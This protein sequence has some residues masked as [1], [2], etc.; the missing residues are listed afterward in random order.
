LTNSPSSNGLIDF[1][2]IAVTCAGVTMEGF[3]FWVPLRPECSY[4]AFPCSL[5]I[6]STYWVFTMRLQPAMILWGIVSLSVT[7]LVRAQDPLDEMY[8]QAVHSFFRGDAQRAEE[9]LTEV[10][11]AGSF[12]P[13]AY[14]FR[15]LCQSMYGAEAGMSDFDRGAELEMEGKKVVN[16]GKALERIQGPARMAIEKAR[17]KARLASRARLLELQRTRYEEMQRAG[18]APGGLI[19]P[20][21]MLD[22]APM[23]GGLAPNDPFNKGMTTGEPKP[24]EGEPKTT[25]PDASAEP[26]TPKPAE[27]TPPTEPENPFGN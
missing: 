19:V 18:N 8:G 23:P 16:V 20:P 17:S 4:R 27:P 6:V 22:P 12:D 10:I 3:K 21:N 7:S 15:G 11:D 1:Y 25:V 13:R 2:F 24:V 26:V 9:L 5:A 14:Y